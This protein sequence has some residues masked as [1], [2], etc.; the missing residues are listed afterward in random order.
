MDAYR[1]RFREIDVIFFSFISLFSFVRSWTYQL[2]ERD[3]PE[4]DYE[5]K[6]FIIR[7]QGEIVDIQF[8]CFNSCHQMA[9]VTDLFP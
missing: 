3:M 9:S 2:E 5:L 6:G 1:Q 7:D 4:D 8:A